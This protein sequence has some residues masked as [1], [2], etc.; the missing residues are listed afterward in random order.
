M[1]SSRVELLHLLEQASGINPGLILKH[2]FF[3]CFKFSFFCKKAYTRIVREFDAH[4]TC[5]RAMC[6]YY[7][8]HMILTS[9]TRYL[10]GQKAFKSVLRFR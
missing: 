4:I 8:F 10:H 3:K 2:V 5:K 6:M 1:V 9:N 7:G